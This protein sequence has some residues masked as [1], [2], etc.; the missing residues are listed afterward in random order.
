MKLFI[1][2]RYKGKVRLPKLDAL[3]A[4]VGLFATVQFAGHIESMKEQLKEQG[5]KP[6]LYKPR[7]AAYKGQILGC[8][9][10]EFPKAKSFLYIGD[11][12]FHPLAIAYRNRKPVFTYN[13]Y[14]KKLSRIDDK[15]VDEY[16][17]RKSALLKRF[18]MSE[19]IGI[20]VSLKPGQNRLKE[21]INL[22]SRIKKRCYIL[23]A[24]E[25]NLQGLMDFPFIGCYV[26]TACPRI[27][28]DD[29]S[30]ADKPIVELE[31]ILSY[32]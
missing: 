32:A 12:R 4:P 6:L 18:L 7:H 30:R 23:V 9:I 31:D 21:A 28:Y 5:K 15:E 3:E 17:K 25:I 20:L 13:P 11:G 24:D 26:N 16:A 29:Y 10:E 1:E 22:R 14:S 19:T 2:A 8:S 27:S